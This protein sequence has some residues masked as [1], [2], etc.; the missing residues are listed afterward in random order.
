MASGNIA[1]N[2]LLF[3]LGFLAIGAWFGGLVL[4]IKPDGSLFQ[5]DPAILQGSFSDFFIPGVI[6]LLVFGLFPTLTIVGLI[7]KPDIKWL[8][9]LNLIHDYHFAWTFTVY[10]GIAM[11]IWINIQTLILNEVHFIHTIYSSLGILIICIALIPSVRLQYK[12]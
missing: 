5:M 1:K 7:R 12:K 4:I 10:I 8:N 2:F 11:I 3:L 9:Y 6:L